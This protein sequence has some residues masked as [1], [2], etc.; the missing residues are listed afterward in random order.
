MSIIPIG[1]VFWRVQIKS[2][3]VIASPRSHYRVKTTANHDRPYSADEIDFLVA[4]IFPEDTWYVFPVALIENR[5]I[6]CLWPGSK[7]SRFEPYREAW[8][9]MGPAGVEAAAEAAAAAV[10][11]T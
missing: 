3:S 6:I 10:A 2:V 1:K 8:K 4:Y 9:L 11:A 7:R 5:K